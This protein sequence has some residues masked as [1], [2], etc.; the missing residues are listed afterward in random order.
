MITV[1]VDGEKEAREVLNGMAQEFPRQTVA[2]AMRDAVKPF[3]Q[4]V[5]N[6][7]PFFGAGKLARSRLW[8]NEKEP[9]L[10]VGVFGKRG[11]AGKVTTRTKQG[12]VRYTTRYI[13]KRKIFNEQETKMSM[14]YVW[15]WV[16]W[17]TLANRNPSYHFKNGR[18]PASSSMKGGIKSTKTVDQAWE[19]NKA[20]VFTRFQRSAKSAAERYARKKNKKGIATLEKTDKE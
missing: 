6:N 4:A 20:N 10:A 5:E 3:K 17:G 12:R 13:K 7:A 19:A 1:K 14:W 11:D 2:A 16:E 15:Y 8:M 9:T 18:K